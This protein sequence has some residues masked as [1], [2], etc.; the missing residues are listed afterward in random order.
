MNELIRI[1]NK[2]DLGLVVSSRTLAEELGRRHDN[3]KRDLENIL[4]SSNVSALIF[5]SEYKDSRGRTQE[6]YLLTKDGFTLYMFNI[7]GQ[8]DFKM[9]Y[10]SKF[11]EMENL[12]KNN[13]TNIDSYMIADP[14][15]RAKKWIEEQEVRK[16]L[17]IKTAIQEQQIGELKPKADY[18]DE[19]LKSYGT[20]IT[21]QI[22]ADYGISAQ[23][24]N[25]ILHKAKLQRKVNNQWI[26]YTEH[27]N[28]SYTESDTIDIVRSDGRKDTVIQTR[29]TQ[30]GRL[31]IHEIMTSLGYEAKTSNKERRVT[32]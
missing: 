9:A 21:T 18:V 12:I 2:Q 22:A 17:E 1:E 4:M 27:M 3:V 30:K 13:I 29:W 10:I 19:I 26:L 7:Q 5:K 8:N 32:A 16:Q 20:V 31:K 23:K 24:L 14:V 15:E 25:K 11:N 28:K 6:E